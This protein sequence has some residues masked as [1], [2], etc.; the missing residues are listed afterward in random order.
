MKKLTNKQEWK[1][2]TKHAVCPLCGKKM[3]IVGSQLSQDLGGTVFSLSC[4]EHGYYSLD[5]RDIH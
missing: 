5:V 2:V 3:Q 1:L 4:K